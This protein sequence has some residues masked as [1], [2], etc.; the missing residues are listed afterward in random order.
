MPFVASAAGTNVPGAGVF[1]PQSALPANPGAPKAERRARRIMGWYDDQR[2]SWPVQNSDI[3]TPGAARGVIIPVPNLE[4]LTRRDFRKRY[5]LVARI[6]LNAADAPYKHKLNLERDGLNLLYLKNVSDDVWLARIVA[7]SGEA[8]VFPV[9]R[10][11][12]EDLLAT[13]PGFTVP[14]AIRWRWHPNDETI[15]I[16]CLVGCCEV[17]SGT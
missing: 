12:H 1:A 14:G 5:Q 15:W 7:P 3:P 10:R 9:Q 13:Y 2:L 8:R 16:P 4:G 17:Q 11:G 6:Y